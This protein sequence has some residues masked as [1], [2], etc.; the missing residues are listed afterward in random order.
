MSGKKKNLKLNQWLID[1]QLDSII[2]SQGQIT[3]R[4][5]KENR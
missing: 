5:T 2:S 4:K 1:P 3:L